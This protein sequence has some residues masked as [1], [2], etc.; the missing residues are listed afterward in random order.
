MYKIYADSDEI[1]VFKSDI[2]YLKA[3]RKY[4]WKFSLTFI[5]NNETVLR[6]SVNHI[7]FKT[8]VSIQEHSFTPTLKIFWEKG[9]VLTTDILKLSIK[10]HWFKNPILTVYNFNNLV[11]K[12]STNLGMVLGTE[13]YDVEL[14]CNED[15]EIFCLLVIILSL[16][17]PIY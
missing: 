6:I 11:G 10:R 7:F 14:T 8:F 16:P 17:T 4:N 15:E 13:E 1:V 9:I 12:V 2:L 5:R 3:K